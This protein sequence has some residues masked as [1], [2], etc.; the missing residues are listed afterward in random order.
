M[1]HHPKQPCY[2]KSTFFHSDCNLSY[3]IY[4]FLCFVQ[5]PIELLQPSLPPL[6]LFS[7]IRTLV[8]LCSGTVRILFIAVS[9]HRTTPQKGQEAALAYHDSSDTQVRISPTTRMSRARILLSIVASHS[10]NAN[11]H[12]EPSISTAFF[13]SSIL[14]A[15]S[16]LTCRTHPLGSS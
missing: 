1:Q 13:E 12:P 14:S 11:A 3:L 7:T 4:I 8:C 10:P 16:R 9:S 15:G 5:F 6:L 2:P